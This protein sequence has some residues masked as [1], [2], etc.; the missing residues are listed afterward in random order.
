MPRSLSD[1]IIDPSNV[2]DVRF[3]RKPGR[4]RREIRFRFTIRVRVVIEIRFL[5]P[6]ILGWEERE[7]G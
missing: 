1:G 4:G 7:M 2:K 6:Q 5:V 3:G